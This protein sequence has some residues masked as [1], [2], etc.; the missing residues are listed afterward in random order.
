MYPRADVLRVYVFSVRDLT[1]KLLNLQKT[2][3]SV[4]LTAVVFFLLL[5]LL[6]GG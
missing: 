5:L 2:Y 6:W 1:S 4:F 3:N